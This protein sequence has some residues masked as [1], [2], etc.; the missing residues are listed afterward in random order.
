MTKNFV[1]DEQLGHFARRQ[2]DFFE[3]VR[4]GAVG[5]DYAM[6]CIQLAA[7]NKLVF[8]NKYLYIIPG[9]EALMLDA[10]FGGEGFANKNDVFSVVNMNLDNL[11][12]DQPGLSTKEARVSVY[13]VVKGGNYSEIFG[14]FSSD[15]EKLCLT[16]EQIKNFCKKYRQWLK[17]NGAGTFFLYKSYGNLFVAEVRFSFNESL[18]L[19][20]LPFKY[21]GLH[22]A[23]NR[24]RVV[25]PQFVL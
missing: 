12:A 10:T 14:S 25:V 4:K 19:S 13:E 6:Y 9:A 15:L 8:P 5:F 3:R 2:H 20:V 18:D 22:S 16:P 17:A 23:E 11:G 7:E 21:T 24:Y 1:T